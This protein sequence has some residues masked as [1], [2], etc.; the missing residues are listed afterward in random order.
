MK[1]KHQTN[2]PVTPKPNSQTIWDDQEK[3]AK[4]K[5]PP[6]VLVIKKVQD[7]EINKGN[8]RQVEQAI[9]ANNIP[10]TKSYKN[11]IG[12][13]VLVC[14]KKDTR[15]QLKTAVESLDAEIKNY[16]PIESRHNIT[17]VG[18][19]KEYNK[20]ELMKMLVMQ[21]GFIKDFATSNDLQEHLKIFAVCPL[22]KNPEKFQIFANISRLL[23]EFLNEFNNNL[24]LGLNNCKIY[25]RYVIKRC[26]NCQHFGHFKRDCPTADEHVCG[27]CGDE[28]ETKECLQTTVK[29]CI[30]CV[31]KNVDD[32]EHETNSLNC[33][34]LL[35]QKNMLKN[36]LNF[37]SR[38]AWSSH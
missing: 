19:P 22:R 17:I 13:L 14:G 15:D 24:T 8:E 21:N 37:R 18:L 3:L 29:R 27:R 38:D 7:N 9:M 35:Q 31:R 20:D 26:T 34:S 12:D 16:T 2:P 10:V 4:I 1:K 36:R 30:N 32:I 23:R 28:H 25:D 5:S 33:A 6:P 11:K